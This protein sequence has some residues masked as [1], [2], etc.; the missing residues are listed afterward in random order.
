MNKVVEILEGDLDLLEMPPKPFLSQQMQDDHQDHK[1]ESNNI[2]LP[3][4]STCF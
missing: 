4:L 3:Q 2:E 1:I